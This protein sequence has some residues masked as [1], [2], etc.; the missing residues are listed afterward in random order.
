MNFVHKTQKCVLLPRLLRI[1]DQGLEASLSCLPYVYSTG[2]PTGFLHKYDIHENSS[3]KFVILKPTLAFL[4]ASF[5]MRNTNSSL[6][7]LFG[8]SLRLTKLF[9]HYCCCQLPFYL[10]G[11]VEPTVSHDSIPPCSTRLLVVGFQ[12]FWQSPVSDKPTLYM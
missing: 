2:A 1:L 10:L 8:K 7:D 12:R 5:L 6:S 4:A 3:N 11:V 9:Y